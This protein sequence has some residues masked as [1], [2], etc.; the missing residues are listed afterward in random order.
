[1][2]TAFG[3]ALLDHHRGERTAPLVQRDG[4]HAREHPIEEFYFGS[5]DPDGDRARWLAKHLAGPLVDLG[6]GA[7]RDSLHFQERFETVAVD[8]DPA[9]V[10]LAADRGV[11]DARE[12][13][14]F[15]L[16]ESFERDR[17]RAA[18]SWGTQ[19]GLAGSMDGLRTFLADLA[20]VTT[21]DATAVVDCYDPTAEAA[22][23]LLGYRADPA[24]GLASRVLHFEYGERVDETLLFRLFSPDRLRAATVSTDWSV[25]EVRRGD[26]GSHYAA[27]L[28]K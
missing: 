24:P 21:P 2:E 23:A 18:L 20:H 3:Q 7:G 12:A 1:M 10:E 28:A 8:P 25:V 15:A 11:D 4:E 13:D 22:T 26:G 9:L 14:M 19:L 17:F 27:A 5:V 16:R 6:A